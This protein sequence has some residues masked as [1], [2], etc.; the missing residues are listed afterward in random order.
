MS[1]PSKSVVVDQEQAPP[2][3]G[4]I[5]TNKDGEEEVVL[6]DAL[7]DVAA[8]TKTEKYVQ[9]ASIASMGLGAASLI[10]SFIFGQNAAQTIANVGSIFTPP[11]AVKNETEITNI[12]AMEEVNERM[13]RENERMKAE[14]KRLREILD[15]LDGTTNKFED[16][17]DTLVFIT[18]KQ[19]F[20]VDKFEKQ[21]REQ[22]DLLETMEEQKVAK[23]MQMFLTIV[24]KSD[25]D[26][27]FKIDA[28]ELDQLVKQLEVVPGMIVNTKLFREMALKNNGS[29]VAILDI[30]RNIN[31]QDENTLDEEKIM[32]LEEDAFGA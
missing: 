12:A 28:A 18:K 9:I 27:D 21:V 25:R 4:T 32:Y 15:G 8:R 22:K 29:L 13:I 19:D 2:S 31:E 26:G 7:Q 3:Y 24:I 10:Y 14:N 20:N 16:G 11:I 5:K 30:L 6:T 23:I 17:L 1:A